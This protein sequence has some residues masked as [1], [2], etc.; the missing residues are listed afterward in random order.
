MKRGLLLLVLATFALGIERAH[1]QTAQQETLGARDL[2]IDGPT[3]PRTTTPAAV[4]RGYALVVGI[5]QYENI[6]AEKQLK[7]AESDA[8]RLFRILVSQAGGAFPAENVHL[9]VGA[10]ATLTNIRRELEVWLPAVARPGDRVVV[11][12]AGHGFV[13]K[14]RGYLAPVDVDLTRLESTAYSMT[15]LG[16]V[17]ATRINAGWKVLLA[18]ACHSGKIN[19][20]TTSERLDQQFSE[21]PASF[22]TL[23]ATTERESSFEDADLET[24]AGLFSYFVER[25]LKGDADNDPCDGRVTAD[26][27][28]EYTRANVRD[29]A[30]SR[31][32]FQTPTAH[33]DYDP[34]MLL[35]TNLSCVARGDAAP[36]LGNAIVEVNMDDVDVFIDDAF[37]GKVSR[38]KPL[39]VPRLLSGIHTFKAL[40]AGYEPA[41]QKSLIAPGQDTT[42][43]LNLRYPLKSKPS[44]RILNEQGERL[45]FT[46]RRSMDPLNIVPVTRAQSQEDIRSAIG[47]FEQALADDP[48]FAKAAYNLGQARHLAAEIDRS[49]EAYR[50]SLALEPNCVEARVAYAG[51]LLESG[52]PDEA[53]RELLEALRLD[54]RS[55]EGYEKLARAYWAKSAWPSVISAAERSLAFNESMAMAHLWHADALRMVAAGM[56]PGMP[57]NEAYQRAQA[58]YESFLRL[59]N[60]SSSVGERLA[61]HFIGSGAGSR[62]HADREDAYR[63]LRSSGYLGLCLTEQKVGKL[64]RARSYC[65]QALRYRNDDAMTYFLLGNIDR[66]LFNAYQRC[67]YLT[68]AARH[69][70]AMLAINDA[71]AEAGHARHYLDQIRGIAREAHC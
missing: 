66:D 45:L 52:D 47:L 15:D 67:D 54:P 51:V 2:V 60:F 57:R 18:D 30:K 35:G 10:D 50:I 3:A 23:T 61:F 24:G 34:E 8:R 17:M 1:A 29:R 12:F 26:E 39:V 59:T 71:I 49:L 5:S 63:N 68:S 25:A 16:R 58:G 21:L 48:S 70:R 22:L 38:N 7:Y 11:F 19:A 56:T 69:Y 64:L 13:S 62:R 27:L 65:E 6:P 9:L 31:G 46:Q 36:L 4:P 42:V 20:E 41:L 28:I 53:I 32:A 14:G 37:I 43:T 55:S 40:R 44:A 33:G